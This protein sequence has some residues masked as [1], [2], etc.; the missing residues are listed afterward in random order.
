MSEIL[1]VFGDLEGLGPELAAWR[2]SKVDKK[3]TGK[4][5][6]H[7]GPLQETVSVE[8]ALAAVG[9]VAGAAGRVEVDEAA[10]TV[11]IRAHR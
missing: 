10:G 9:R 8:E 1:H 6:R 7:L 11:K 4:L 3:A 2:A 5:P